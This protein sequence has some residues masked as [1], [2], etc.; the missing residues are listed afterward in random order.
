MAMVVAAVKFNKVE[1][2]DIVRS[3]LAVVIAVVGLGCGTSTPPANQDAGSL[4]VIDNPPSDTGA[5]TEYQEVIDIRDLQDPTRDP[6]VPA[7]TWVR[8]AGVVVTAPSKGAVRVFFIQNSGEPT[9]YGGIMVR[10]R[11]FSGELPPLGAIITTLDAKLVEE[12]AC[13][14]GVDAGVCPPRR[15]LDALESVTFTTG[16]I[17]PDP[18]PVATA[19]LLT[20]PSRYNG[21]RV[22]VQDEMLAVHSVSGNPPARFFTE[23]NNKGVAVDT[24]WME[25][26]PSL[27]SPG[28]PILM[29]VGVV[30]IYDHTWVYPASA[31]DL[32]FG[33]SPSQDGG[34]KCEEERS[35]ARQEDCRDPADSRDQSECGARGC[36]CV[37]GAPE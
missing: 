3:V 21:V 11:D 35:C 13:V 26:S 30:D 33:V 34:V 5:A 29:L 1:K 12:N 25:P 19:D 16:G 2:E 36:V 28:T 9:P 37:Y 20:T 27:P 14:G 10:N 4:D 24:M 7:G 22:E 32:V 31:G 23:G 17:V 6:F 8:V 18:L 15:V